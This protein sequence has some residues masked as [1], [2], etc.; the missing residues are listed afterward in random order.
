MLETPSNPTARK[1]FAAG[2]L[3][4]HVEVTTAHKGRFEHDGITTS[5][6]ENNEASR[7]TA[8][9]FSSSAAS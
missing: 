1:R 2:S 8:P 4:R 6:G 9:E 5:S 7:T 3:S